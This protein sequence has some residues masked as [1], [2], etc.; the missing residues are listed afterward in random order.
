MRKLRSVEYFKRTKICAFSLLFLF[1]FFVFAYAATGDVSSETTEERLKKAVSTLPDISKFKNFDRFFEAMESRNPKLQE[2]LYSSDP[3]IKAAAAFLVGKIREI[4]ISREDGPEDWNKEMLSCLMQMAKNTA[5][6]LPMIEASI[7]LQLMQSCELSYMGNIARFLDFSDHY[8]RE[9]AYYLCEKVLLRE[10][11]YC[12]PGDDFIYI[13]I[14]KI[15]TLNEGKTRAQI[16]FLLGIALSHPKGGLSLQKFIDFYLQDFCLHK[17][18]YRPYNPYEMISY[19]DAYKAVKYIPILNEQLKTANEQEGILITKGLEKNK[20]Y[21][22]PSDADSSEAFE[23]MMS[24]WEAIVRGDISLAKSLFKVASFPTR[25]SEKDRDIAINNAKE[26]LKQYKIDQIRN[27][28]IA[29][30]FSR[31]HCENFNNQKVCFSCYVKTQIRLS[32]NCDIKYEMGKTTDEEGWFVT[33][34]NIQVG[35]L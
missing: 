16:R 34:M 25:C 27:S 4:P 30:I 14:E 17:D 21:S 24:F 1:L 33:F 7:T 10:Y 22:R 31:D 12:W 11:P 26:V 23:I 19:L 18:D 35:S 9:R 32:D 5:E 8:I 6:P 29:R 28:V 20:K 3:F 13:L 15:N 2:A